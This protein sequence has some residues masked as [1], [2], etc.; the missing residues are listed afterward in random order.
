MLNIRYHSAFKREF[1]KMQKRGLDMS[2]LKAVVSILASATPLPPKYCDHALSG[3]FK[4][5]RECH[6]EPDWLLIYTVS[7]DELTLILSRTGTHSDLF[8]K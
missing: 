2:K 7:S 1:K 6:I 3:S 8:D 5:F 4:G